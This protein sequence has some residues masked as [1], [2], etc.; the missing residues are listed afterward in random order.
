MLWYVT[1]KLSLGELTRASIL[2]G[3]Q[4]RMVEG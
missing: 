4:I 3:N 2:L 1:V